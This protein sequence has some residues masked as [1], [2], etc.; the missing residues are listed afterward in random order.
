MRVIAAAHDT[1]GLDITVRAFFR[2]PTV[3]TLAPLV[4]RLL[5]EAAARGG[6]PDGPAAPDRMVPVAREHIAYE[7]GK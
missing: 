7:E 3:A 5:G 4:E 6:S 2:A 1:W